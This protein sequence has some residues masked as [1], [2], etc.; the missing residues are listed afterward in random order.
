MGITLSLFRVEALSVN[1]WLTNAPG[2]TVLRSQNK[3]RGN[4][5][6]RQS[7]SYP[8]RIS[9]ISTKKCS[10][11]HFFFAEIRYW[12]A[13][14]LYNKWIRNQDTNTSASLESSPRFITISENQNASYSHLIFQTLSAYN[15]VPLHEIRRFITVFRKIHNWNREPILSQFNPMPIKTS[16]NSLKLKLA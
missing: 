14:C 12:T 10:I 16:S 7:C 2:K 4:Q 15:S 11:Q 6:S 13:F 5:Y 9:W 8:A 1:A 3:R